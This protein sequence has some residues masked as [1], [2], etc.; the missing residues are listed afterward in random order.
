VNAYTHS[1]YCLTF[2]NGKKYYGISNDFNRRM[3]EHERS[4]IKDPIQ[5]YKAIRKYT[6][7]KVIKEVVCDTIS[8]DIAVQL[9]ISAIATD[10]TFG[11]FG[12]NS[13]PGGDGGSVPARLGGLKSCELGLGVHTYAVRSRAGK[14]SKQ[15]GLGVHSASSEQLSKWSMLGASKGGAVAGKIVALRKFKCEVCGLVAN[16][17][18]MAIHQSAKRHQGIEDCNTV[19]LS[20]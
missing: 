8:R 2:P 14:R 4:S 7:D 6:W 15:L 12:Y 19:I 3:K 16:K 13:T 17:G 11:P 1:L 20:D 18:N 10:N 5:V 9:E